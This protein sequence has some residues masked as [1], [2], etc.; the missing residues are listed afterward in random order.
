MHAFGYITPG[1]AGFALF[2][3]L[4]FAA[5]QML[6]KKGQGVL[7]LVVLAFISLA[8]LTAG[9]W[10]M[11]PGPLIEVMATS[12]PLYAFLV[13]L[14][15]HFYFAVVRSLS[16]RILGELSVTESGSMTPAELDAVYPKRTMVAERLDVLVRKGYLVCS[17]DQYQCTAKGRCLVRLAL[18]GKKLYHLDATG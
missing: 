4:H 3:L 13:I 1:V 16:V 10:R 7:A 12:G 9:A 6:P 17:G 8:A 11:S 14:Y 2:L 18:R 15:F 5:W